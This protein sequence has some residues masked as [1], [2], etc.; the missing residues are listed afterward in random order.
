MENRIKIAVELL[1]EGRSFKVGDLRLGM[2]G[3]NILTVTGWSQYLNFFN[4]TK[5]TSLNELAE[6]KDIFSNIVNISNDL[7][8][9]IAGKSI[10][11]ILCYDDGGKASIDI[12]SERNG[13]VKWRIDLK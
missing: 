2:N 5:N 7:K 11:Y 10:E 8:V 3:S 4:L 12:C 1:K 9:F 6:I 13:V